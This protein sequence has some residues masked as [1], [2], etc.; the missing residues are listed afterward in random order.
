MAVASF[1]S[2]VPCTKVLSQEIQIFQETSF[3]V[4]QV[5][6]LNFINTVWQLY[7]DFYTIKIVFANSFQLFILKV[8]NLKTIWQ[9]WQ[10]CVDRTFV[11]GTLDLLMFAVFYHFI[12]ILF[13][14]V[15]LGLVSSVLR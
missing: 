9:F 15:V 5:L 14:F 7:I 8:A 11:H 6:L 13:A 10:K 2:R 1:M 12:P 3:C 4:L